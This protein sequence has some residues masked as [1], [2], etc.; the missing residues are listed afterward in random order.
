MTAI[1]HRRG[2]RAYRRVMLRLITRRCSRSDSSAESPAAQLVR[3]FTNSRF[4][5]I[6]G[7]HATNIGSPPV[8]ADA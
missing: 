1:G 4:Y 7:T 6:S 5:R 3:L 2:P 8:S